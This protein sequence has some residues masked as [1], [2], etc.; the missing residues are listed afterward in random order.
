[1]STDFPL[2]A[3]WWLYAAVLKSS[4]KRKVIDVW[5]KYE[6]L[7]YLDPW[8]WKICCCWLWNPGRRPCCRAQVWAQLQLRCVP[9]WIKCYQFWTP[10]CS[11]SMFV[12]NINNL[13]NFQ[14]GKMSC[15][16]YF[17]YDKSAARLPVSVTRW[18]I[19]FTTFILWK[20]TKS[21]IN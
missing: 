21:L 10:C 5:R 17:N 18:Q 2:S 19:Y 9:C 13:N 12:M 20:I 1:M 8:N 4:G 7:I 6:P 16:A 3:A 11:G 14:N 15:T